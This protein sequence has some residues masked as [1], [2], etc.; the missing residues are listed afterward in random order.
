MLGIVVVVAEGTLLYLA[1]LTLA[2]T[3]ARVLV[4]VLCYNV[5]VPGR[6]LKTTEESRPTLQQQGSNTEHFLFAD[7]LTD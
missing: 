4:T 5:T 7:F 1:K 3:I 2:S 6:F